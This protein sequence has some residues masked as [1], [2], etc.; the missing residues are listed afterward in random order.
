MQKKTKIKEG[1][2]APRVHPCLRALYAKSDYYSLV[3]GFGWLTY[4]YLSLSVL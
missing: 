1:M 3:A 2:I 4:T